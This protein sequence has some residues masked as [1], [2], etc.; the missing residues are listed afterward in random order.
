MPQGSVLRR[1][2]PPVRRLFRHCSPRACGRRRKQRSEEEGGARRIQLTISW[3]RTRLDLPAVNSV[4]AYGIANGAPGLSWIYLALLAVLRRRDADAPDL[5]ACRRSP[6]SWVSAVRRRS[7]RLPSH[8]SF[9]CS[10]LV[11]RSIRFFTLA[12]IHG[13]VG[14]CRAERTITLK[15]SDMLP[16]GLYSTVIQP[17]V[18]ASFIP[19]GA[20]NGQGVL[21]RRCTAQG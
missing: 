8:C 7:R 3:S 1:P 12:A 16:C 13:A 17:G 6:R 4:I 10:R 18:R 15:P 20:G 21:G 14:R 11:C 2:P 19:R 5:R 9:D